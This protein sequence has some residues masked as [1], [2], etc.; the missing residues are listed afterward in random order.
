MKNKITKIAFIICVLLTNIYIAS[1]TPTNNDTIFNKYYEVTE[2]IYHEVVSVNSSPLVDKYTSLEVKDN[3][4]YGFAKY[5]INQTIVSKSTS[6]VNE[7][8]DGQDICYLYGNKS[9]ENKIVSEGIIDFLGYKEIFKNSQKSKINNNTISGTINADSCLGVVRS[10]LANT[11]NFLDNPINFTFNA[12][13][14]YVIYLDSTNS[15]ILAISLDLTSIAKLKNSS[16]KQVVGMVE[17]DLLSDVSET[18][19]KNPYPTE[20]GD[21]QEKIERE[22]KAKG[23]DFIKDCYEEVKYVCDDLTFYTNTMVSPKLS[24]KYSSSNPNVIGNDGKYYPVNFDTNVTITV[25][26]FYSM[27]EYD[28]YSFTFLAIPKVNRSGDLGTLS[29]PLYNGRKPIENVK[30]YFIE[31]HQQYGDAIYIQAGD[32]DMLIDAGQ[33][34]DGGYV[35][36][37]LRRHISDGRLEMVVATHAHGDHIGGMSVALSTIKNITYAIDYGYQRSDYGTVSDI[38]ERFMQADKYSPITDCIDGLNGARKKMYI[39]N[40][41]Y[42]TFLDT[43]YY[44]KPNVDLV[45]GDNYNQ[46]SIALII[47]YKNQHYYFAG[48]LESEGETS[49]VRNGEVHEVDLAKASHHGSSTSNNNTILSALNAK[50]MVVCTALIDRGSETKNASSQYH[51]NGRVLERM[52]NYS[53]VYCNF[54]TGTLEITCDGQNDMI[55]RGFGVSSPYYISGKAISGEENLE[56]KHT[57]YAKQYYSQYI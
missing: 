51:P 18:I 23:L 12:K 24:F 52:L 31:M 2:V 29:N 48:D 35:N 19:N 6:E 14:S 20:I 1:C 57:R 30:I 54:T 5:N 25:S 11:G 49:L 4:L 15:N 50:V 38:R 53:K 8:I 56:F 45:G 22:I 32:F 47:T 9:A 44:V 17:F 41:F 3:N 21:S 36:D 16:V 27:L 33:V 46:T 55:L 10:F 13:V 26:L 7:Y 43:G 39:S 37:V 40:D 34:A 42:I 28:T